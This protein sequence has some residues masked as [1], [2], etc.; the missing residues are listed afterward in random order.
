MRFLIVGAGP[1][2][3]A[4]ALALSGTE[5]QV[6]VVDIG[7]TLE[8]P[9]ASILRRVSHQERRDWT[10]EDLSV[11]TKKGQRSATSRLPQKLTFGSDFPF[12]DAGQIGEMS[13]NHV[14]GSLVS[15]AFGGFS[16]VWGAQAL[17]FATTELAEWPDGTGELARHYAA[18]AGMMPISGSAGDALFQALPAYGEMRRPLPLPAPAQKILD[19]AER[20]R[21]SLAREG[22]TIGQSRIAVDADRCVRCGHC[23]T[24]CPL[25]LTFSARHPL[26]AFIASGAVTYIPGMRAESIQGSDPVRVI[27]TELT[28]SRTVT[29]E[30]DRVLL[31]CGV[32]GSARIVMRSLARFDTPIQ[33]QESMQFTVPVINRRG[34]ADPRREARPTF[35]ELS[36]LVR[37][38]EESPLGHLQLYTYDPA[39]LDALPP[40]FNRLPQRMTAPLLSRLHVGL[41]Y[42]PSSVCPSISLA[43]RRQSGGDRLELT[44]NSAPLAATSSLMRALLRKL[45]RTAGRTGIHPLT[46]LA[47]LSPQGKSYHLGGSFAHA[48]SPTTLQTNALG[49]IASL[50]RVHLVDASVL[51]MISST[52]ITYTVMA[53][54]H[55][56]TNALVEGAP[57]S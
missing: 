15:G 20:H 43:L 45:G 11:L 3:A 9:N 12:R 30:A 48:T 55:R 23:M 32:V 22:V 18:V 41:G 25:D 1:A 28:S 40:L 13:Q 31:A 27:C 33:I 7:A 17:P 5:H 4:A 26:H 49:E 36:L 46:P 47:R 39:L 38:R 14:E 24:G 50:P 54:A 56:I 35:G 19:S 21:K 10:T 34:S 8:E 53:N 37:F 2:A 51:P 6:T 57:E 42:L 44:A 52:T 16:N 29:F